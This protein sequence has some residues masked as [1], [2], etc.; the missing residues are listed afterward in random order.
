M[1]ATVYRIVQE[2][3][4]NAVK[5]AG[6][7]TVVVEVEDRGGRLRLSVADDGSGFE[8]EQGHEGFG[9]LGMRERVALVGG[10]FAVVSRPGQGTAVSATLPVPVRRDRLDAGSHHARAVS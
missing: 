9:L 3:L 2:A 6:A 7:T 5:H 4:T 10:E 1:E 8:P